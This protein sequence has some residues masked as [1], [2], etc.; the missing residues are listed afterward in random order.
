MELLGAPNVLLELFD[1]C[2]YRKM[3]DSLLMREMCWK[4]TVIA[5]F[6]SVVE[7]G[8]NI[9][10]L[11]LCVLPGFGFEA[12]SM[13]NH[14]L[15]HWALSSALSLIFEDSIRDLGHRR[16]RHCSLLSLSSLWSSPRILGTQ[17][18]LVFVSLVLN[19]SLSISGIVNLC[20]S[21]DFVKGILL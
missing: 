18:T 7:S 1:S 14:V 8:Q 10:E 9:S 17:V 5:S 13:L 12:S 20:K 21:G 19:I 4:V 15:Y 11:C 2:L 3:Y 6:D 16:R